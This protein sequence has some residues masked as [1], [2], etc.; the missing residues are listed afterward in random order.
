M[1][2]SNP[3]F[4]TPAFSRYTWLQ[5]GALIRTVAESGRSRVKLYLGSCRSAHACNDDSN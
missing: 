2:L 5:A 3:A 4:N 1:A